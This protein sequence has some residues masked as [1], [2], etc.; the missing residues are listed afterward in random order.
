MTPD[1]WTQNPRSWRTRSLSH[2]PISNN[3]GPALPS[4]PLSHFKAIDPK[5]VFQKQSDDSISNFSNKDND[6]MMRKV[7]IKW[8][9]KLNMRTRKR[10][11]ILED[12][13]L[14]SEEQEG[15]CSITPQ[16]SLLFTLQKA[17]MANTFGSSF[18]P[19]LEEASTLFKSD[20]KKFLVLQ[21]IKMLLF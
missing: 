16:N 1:P 9:K 14:E 13:D 18:E 2:Y 6:A 21:V 20:M 12:E 10:K 8:I 4:S 3:Q 17:W 7:M 11:E 19:H 5:V 15:L